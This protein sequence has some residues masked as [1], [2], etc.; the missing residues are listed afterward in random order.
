MILLPVTGLY[1]VFLCNNAV[2]KNM[3]S[4]VRL[5]YQLCCLG[6]VTEPLF[7]CS[8]LI[9][10]E[11]VVTRIHLVDYFCKDYLRQREH[12]TQYVAHSKLLINV[13]MLVVITTIFN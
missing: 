2:V 6:Q 12:L 13:N 5:P 11:G 8:F 3:G 9:C 10:K 4:R 1:E 7:A